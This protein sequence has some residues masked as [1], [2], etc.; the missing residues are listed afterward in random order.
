MDLLIDTHV[1]L[2]WDEG[3]RHLPAYIHDAIANP[4]NRI[5]VSAATVWEI[6]IKRRIGKLV[7]D[8][9]IA[10][11]VEINGFMSLPMT[12]ADAEA[13]GALDWKHADPFDRMILA[14]CIAGNLTLVTADKQMR[15]RSEIAQIWAG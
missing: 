7:F 6:A 13:A 9:P 3:A 2:W 12:A 8:R 1:F 14:Q 15:T 11:S 10:E 4:E 5:F